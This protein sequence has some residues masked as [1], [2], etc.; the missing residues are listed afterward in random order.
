VGSPAS[1]R[2]EIAADERTI[3]DGL[4]GASQAASAT[5]EDGKSGDKQE[6]RLALIAET[7]SDGA[8][9]LD[10]LVRGDGQEGI[11]AMIAAVQQNTRT[12]ASSSPPARTPTTIAWASP[13][14]S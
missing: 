13:G 8:D 5:V 3:S 9:Y 11:N 12:T 6:R 7:F 1:A 2:R 14:I 4:S 10:P